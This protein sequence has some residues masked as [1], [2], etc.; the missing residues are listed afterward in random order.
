MAEKRKLVCE[1]CGTDD[2]QTLAWVDPN[3]KQYMGDTHDDEAYCNYCD[4]D[5]TLSLIIEDDEGN[6]TVVDQIPEEGIVIPK[7]DIRDIM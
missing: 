6:E 5:T 2:I 4:S 1:T 3:T 7:M